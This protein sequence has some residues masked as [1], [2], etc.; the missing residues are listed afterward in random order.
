MLRNLALLLL[1]STAALADTEQQICREQGQALPAPATDKPGRKYMRDRIARIRHLALDVTPDFN[2]RNISGT[3]KLTF[4]PIAQPLSQF[5]LDAVGLT[6]ENITAQGAT[7]KAHEVTADKIV[8]HFDPALPVDAEAS[9]TITYHAEP[10]RGLYFRTPEMGYQKGD[11]QVWS[12]GEPELHHFWF[13]SYDYPNQ[14][15]TT[16]VTCHVPEGMEVISNGALASHD[17]DM[18]G[19][20]AWHWKQ[21]KPHP[22]YLIGL[23]AG[24]F[25][26]LEEKTG[27]VPLGLSVPPSEK[28]QAANAFLDTKHIIE[29]YQRETGVPFAWDKY[30]QVYLLDF[31]AGGMENTS[32]TFE[33]ASL[34]FRDDTEQLRTLRPLDAHETAHQWFGDLVTCRDWAHLWLNEGFAT[35]YATLYEGEA[36]GADE[37]RYTLWNDAHKVYEALDGKPIV[38]RDYPDPQWQFDY[39]NYPKASWCLHMIRSRL[40]PDLY[41]RCIHTYLERHRGGNVTTDDIQAVFEELSGLSFDQFFDQWFYHG[42][43]P[44]LKVDYSWDAANKQA[45]L[46][47]KQTQKISPEVLLY[48]L[49]IPVRFFM[50]GAEKSLDF[51]VDLK[52]AEED[53]SFPLPAAPELIRVDPDYTLLAKWDF[54]P[55]PDMLKRQLKADMI[56]RLLAVQALAKKKDEDTVKLLTAVLNQDDFHGVRGEA[57]K[58]LKVIGTPAA[59]RALAQSTAQPDARVRRDVVEALG[60]FALPETQEA[61]WKLS[62][63]EKNPLILAAIIK[64]WGTQPG[65]AK[66][67]AALRKFVEMPSYHQTLATAAINALRAQ[68]DTSAAPVVLERLKRD[69]LSFSSFAL[70]QVLDALA[71]LARQEKD[72]EPVRLFLAGYLHHPRE[73][74]RVAAAKGLG[75]LRDPKSIAL[76]QPLGTENKLYKDPVTEAAE[77]SIAALEAELTKPQELKDVWTKLQDLQKKSEDLEKQFER[78]GKK[79]EASAAASKGGEEKK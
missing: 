40:G 68:D 33:T 47:I 31:V 1:A 48:R 64:T 53:F 79:P 3:S 63:T 39:R 35:Y 13:P 25:H 72:R 41:R 30:H 11:T 65:D 46:S 70:P 49:Q 60:S 59:R 77:K 6:V 74:L 2:K 55:S 52:K 50:P 10:Q 76:L 8:L 9:V 7:L 73:E 14:R 12:Q 4:Q 44:E 19:L 38:W 61:L 75:T 28:D 62:Q 43:L 37:M 42:G 27:S 23:A 66:I 71:F 21:D 17:K 57:A 16:E 56:G 34:L 67:A 54:T 69:A 24:Y 32:C 15:F 51:Q 58:A 5:E 26:T 78:I 29:F 20:V 22:N 36:K 45:K 18:R